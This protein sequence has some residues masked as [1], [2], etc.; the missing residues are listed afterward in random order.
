MAATRAGDGYWL[1]TSAGHVLAYGGAR[2]VGGAEGR[3]RA[4]VV[5]ITPAS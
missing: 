3:A 1:A 4:P 2:A 5:A